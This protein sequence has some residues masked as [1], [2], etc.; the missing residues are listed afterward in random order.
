MV[1]VAKE[2]TGPSRAWASAALSEGTL[3]RR[4]D[5]RFKK[6][7]RSVRRHWGLY[8][9]LLVPLGFLVV[10]NYWPILGAQIAFRNY[11]PIQ[12][13]W[14]S[15][16]TGLEQFRF[17]LEDPDFWPVMRNTLVLSLYSLLVGTPATVILALMLNEVRHLRFKRFVQTATYFPYFISVIVLVGMMQLILSPEVGPLSAIYH[18]FGDQNVPDLFGNANDFAS[19]YVWSGVWQTTGYGAIIYLG[20]LSTVDP[21]LYE[22]ARIDGASLLQKIRHVDVPAITP[23][24]VILL[25]LTVGNVLGV[26]FEKVFLMQTPLNLSSSQVVSTYVYQTGLVEDNFSFGTA[27]GIFN[28]LIT[29]FLLVVANF[30]AKRTAKTSLF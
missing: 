9:M 7:G 24:I 6:A 13:I 1:S 25:I 27:V 22:A 19:L 15:P 11:N 3:G 17:W 30:I 21:T 10:F 28:S 16:W 5:G 20:V 4:S 23:T 8:V 12:G 18:L 14:G 29:L 2:T 26:G